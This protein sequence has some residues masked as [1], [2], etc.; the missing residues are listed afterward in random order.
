MSEEELFVQKY[1]NQAL[2]RYAFK[3]L[4][5]MYAAVGFGS[6][7]ANKII[8]RTLEEYRKYHKE[9]NVEEKIEELVATPKTKSSKTGIIVKGIDN[10]LVRI[11][12]CCNPVPGDEIIGY[13]TRGRGV[14]VH[15]KNCTNVKDLLQDDGRIIDVY[16][17]EQKASAY[18]VDITILAN[19]R[20][21]LLS[22]VIKVIGNTNTKL[23]G[24]SAKASKEKIAMVEL[25]IE[26][27]DI[28]G[29]VKAQREVGKKD[30]VYELKRNK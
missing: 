19:D 17:D 25:T 30:S 9:E 15:R 14:T 28:N 4:E 11:S 6:I 29:L 23:V 16:W 26:V 3:T 1:Y 18:N 24:V 21:G 22:D 2:Q 20:E 5:D 13:I 10:C 8:A 12:K 7:T 27:K